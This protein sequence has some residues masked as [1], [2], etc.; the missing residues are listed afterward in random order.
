MVACGAFDHL[1]RKIELI[2][3]EICEMNPA[4]PVHDD[5]I[6]YLLNWSIRETPQQAVRV[7]AQTGLDLTELES[8]PEPDLLWIKAGRYR[9]R[10]PGA[11]DVK[12]AI[13]VSGNS[14][15]AD[16]NRKA[17][18]Y[19]Q[20]KIVEYWIVDVNAKCIHR[21]RDP[22]DGIYTDR[23]VTKVGELLSPLEP[24]EKP[25]DLKDLFEGK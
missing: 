5:F 2:R 1:N 17:A 14:L 9:D 21:F 18:L 20:A 13:E 15:A 22:I 4:G 7:T 25:L 3:G 23:S 12:L 11:K 19:A 6:N 16:M 24:C 8:R 10:H